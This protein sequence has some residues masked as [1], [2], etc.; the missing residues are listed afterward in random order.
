MKK[1]ICITAL[2]AL[3]FVAQASWPVSADRLGDKLVFAEVHPWAATALV[4]GAW[5]RWN[6]TGHRPDLNDVMSAYWPLRGIYSEG[7]CNSVAA[8]GDDL[9]GSISA[10]GVDVMVI[11]WTGVYTN[12]QKRVESILKCSGMRAI[13]MV[14]VNW[15]AGQSSFQE[16]ITR[17]ETVIGWYA[18]RTDLY[19]NYYR[20]PATGAP[21]FIVYDPGATGSAAQWNSKINYYKNSNPRGI[22]IAGLG[23]HTS[24]S[25]ALSSDFDGVLMLSSKNA[26]SDQLTIQ[27]VLSNIYGPSSR[28]Q[29]VLAEA[30]PGFNNYSNCDSSSPDILS[31]QDGDVFDEKWM[32]II[33]SN[34]SGHGVDG[35][36]VMYNNDGES[37]GIE[38]ASPMPPTREAGFNS[39]NGRLS[40]YYDTYYPLP[41]TYYLDRNAYWANKFRSAP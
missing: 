2:M 27:W 21:V 11:D 29:F 30:I 13:V 23:A 8:Q 41:A 16:T 28:G 20:D 18:K 9:S 31:R 22:F 36:Y 14:D 39:C 17:L 3:S 25:W 5:S 6:D 37:A 40:A 4:D 34:W 19:P 26:S 32:G 1:W 15:K 10:A 24:V 35:A 7:D 33:E 38:A 12:E